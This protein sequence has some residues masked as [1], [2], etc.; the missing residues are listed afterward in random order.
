MVC[1]SG[2]TMQRH[3]MFAVLGL[4]T[5]LALSTIGCAADIDGRRYPVGSVVTLA[6][7]MHNLSGIR[8]APVTLRWG[9]HLLRP[10]FAWPKGPILTEY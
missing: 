7:G 3:F 9:D 10:A 8:A 4:A 2:G 1:M 5:T 6:R